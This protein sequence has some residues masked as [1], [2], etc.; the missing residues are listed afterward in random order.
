[1]PK[2]SSTLMRFLVVC[3]MFGAALGYVRNAAAE[4]RIA[5]VIG[6]AAY[7]ASPLRNPVNDA[8]AVA[9]SLNQ[10]GFEVL[11]KT[12]LNLQSMV[13]AVRELGARLKEGDV[14]LVYYSGHGMQVK[15]RNFL[16]PVN[17]DIRGEDEVPYMSLDVSQVLDKL[18]T[19]RSRVNIVVLDACRSNPY[20]RTFRTSR[21]GLAQMDAP[22][23]T[24]I[25]FS[26]APGSEA[27]DGDAEYGTYTRHLLAHMPTPGLP[28]EVMFRRVRENVTAETKDRQVPWESSSLKGDFY[29]ARAIEKPIA[30]APAPA[31]VAA[32]PAEMTVEL[33]FWDSIKNST[34]R[35]DFEEYLQQYP[36]GRFAGLARNRVKGVQQ[37][38]PAVAN[39]PPAQSAAPEAAA[40]EAARRKTQQDEI[41][42]AVVAALRKREAELAAAQA[43]KV[44]QESQAA[45][46]SIARLTK[47]LAEL[48]AMPKTEAERTAPPPQLQTAPQTIA[49]PAGSPKPKETVSSAPQ[50]ALAVPSAPRP[51][52]VIEVGKRIERP[53]IRVG[54]QWKYQI[55]ESYTGEKRTVTMGV[56][57]VNE[58]FIYTQSSQSA[59]AALNPSTTGGAFDVW[60]HNWNQVRQ[61]EIEYAPFYP[62]MQFPLETGKKWSGTVKFDVSH[63]KMVH[64]LEAQ[65]AGWER[66]TVPAGTF[67][68]VKITL[69]G[70]FK[71]ERSIGSGTIRDVVWYA[72]AIRQIVKKEV[73]QRT[74]APGTMHS[75]FHIGNYARSE[76][77]ELIEYK[78]N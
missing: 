20:I 67:D 48:R 11:L 9:K 35:A 26:T 5:L 57:T 52:P 33:A 66:V 34:N 49:Q 64:Q 22:G 2:G 29:F 18:E 63:G 4:Q 65:V 71:I 78:L 19:A 17:A 58:N 24:L 10:L 59:L 36:N 75:S 3:V 12:N 7:S 6:N 28:V 13:E 21:V 37:A 31:A 51:K 38:A 16:I 60:N 76:I 14:V 15:G 77:W 61:G 41:E 42:L 40:N 50:I 46:A 32:Q 39:P 62:S 68:A 43:A 73:Q 69:S 47:E 56:V 45:R 55:T 74:F 70:D 8:R 53:D 25:A 44:E 27:R 30:A 23:G 72:P 54:D 1:V